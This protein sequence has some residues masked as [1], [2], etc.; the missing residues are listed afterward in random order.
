[1]K[2]RYIHDIADGLRLEIP[3]EHTEAGLRLEGMALVYAW[4]GR[5]TVTSWEPLAELLDREDIAAIERA[6]LN[7]NCNASN[8]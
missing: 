6:I 7:E 2:P 1:M 4:D 8:T 5:R 3:Y